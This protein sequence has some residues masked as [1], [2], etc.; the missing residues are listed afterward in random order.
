MPFGFSLLIKEKD[1]TM[2]KKETVYLEC[3]AEQPFPR[4]GAGLDQP[5]P[6]GI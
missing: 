1:R 3:I 2:Q 5:I 4:H 6:A